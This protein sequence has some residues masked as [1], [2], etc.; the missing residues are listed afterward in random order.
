MAL[1]LQL[2]T[3]LIVKSNIPEYVM[4]GNKN[5]KVVSN[6]LGSSIMVVDLS[7]YSVVKN[8]KYDSFGNILLDSDPNFE[9]PFR[10][11]GGLWDKDTKLVR[12]D[13]R[14]LQSNLRS[15]Y[16][17]ETGRWTSKE[18]LGFNGARNFYVYVKNNPVMYY[19][20]D[21]LK[22]IPIT[23]ENDSEIFKGGL[24]SFTIDALSGVYGKVMCKVVK[25]LQDSNVKIF[26]REI[27]RRITG[28]A[29]M[30]RTKTQYTDTNNLKRIHVIVSMN[31]IDYIKNGKRY[32]TNFEMSLRHEFIHAWLRLKN[33][34]LKNDDLEE[35]I[36][37]KLGAC[38][39]CGK[40]E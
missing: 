33:I 36:A 29:A 38:G 37:N 24:E 15:S 20:L 21:G 27:P 17:S 18:P 1:E 5:Y 3:T 34:D 6:Y 32:Y 19:D 30:K 13:V 10:F 40:E 25:D 4:K 9:L 26:V 39:I 23:K 7:D 28:E 31:I 12:F 14:E 16:D 35:F 22:L 11:A 8:I 2:I